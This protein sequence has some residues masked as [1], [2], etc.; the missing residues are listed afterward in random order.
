MWGLKSICRSLSLCIPLFLLPLLS[1]SVELDG[2]PF[3]LRCDDIQAQKAYFENERIAFGIDSSIATFNATIAFNGIPEYF[4]VSCRDSSDKYQKTKSYIQYY[5]NNVV[6][7]IL[8]IHMKMTFFD[9]IIYNLIDSL[10]KFTNWKYV[11]IDGEHYMYL[12]NKNTNN[13]AF[14]FHGINAMNGMENLYLLRDLTKQASVYIMI[15]TPLFIFESYNGYSHTF[16]ER[17][18]NVSRFIQTK[19]VESDAPYVIMGNSFGSIQV[20]SMCKQ[21]PETCLS[22]SKII[23]TDPV[24]LTMPYSRTHDALAFGVFANHDIY[25]RLFNKSVAVVSV[26][27]QPRFYDL[28]LHS[29]DW[30][31]WSIDSVFIRLYA[32]QLVLVVGTNDNMIDINMKSPILSECQVIY[33]DTSHGMVIFNNF[34]SQIDLWNNCRG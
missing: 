5:I 16:D 19:T 2:N 32:K 6:L 28:L 15:Y 24:T 29:V 17:L 14:Y 8:P 23:L 31:E 4:P 22:A 12:E 25:T 27:R 30:Y 33:T 34:M 1:R 18:S 10:W 9:S 11:I 26:L 7:P 20:T 21:Y 13:V 3:Y